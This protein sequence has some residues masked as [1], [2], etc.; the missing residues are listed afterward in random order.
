MTRILRAS[1]CLVATVALVACS[2]QD[3][4]DDPTD[5]PV[6]AE[7]RSPRAEQ[8]M[9]EV[10]AELA[11]FYEQSLRWEECGDGF[12]CTEVTVPLD[13][14]EPDGET[15]TIAVKRRAAG[16]EEPVGSLLVN[17]G[18][19][20]GSGVQL[21]ESA[22]L[23]FSSELLDGFDVIGFDPRGVNDSSA[24]DC[25][26]DAELDRIR[27]EDYDE[28]A[29]GLAEFAS[30][31]EELAAACAE[32]TGDLLAHVDTVSAARDVDVVRHL[33]EE[34]RLD[35][36]GYSYGTHLGAVYA[37]LFPE[38][39]GRLVLDGAMDPS[40]GT[41]E[42]VRGQAAGF[43]R[44]LRV[45]VEDCLAGPG[46]PLT[47][48]V[49]TAVGQ[50]QQLLELA[51]HTPLPTGTDRELTAPLMFSGIIMPLYDDAYWMLLTSALDAAINQQDGS[52]L[53]LLADLSAERE[54]DGTYA[55]NST[56]ANI[57]INC[58]DYPVEGDLETWRAEAKELA[59]ISPT[60]GPALAFGDVTCD[61]WPHEPTV[62]R[63]P[64][65]AA[66][67]DPIVVIGTTGDPAT[68]Y[69][70]SEA[71]AA[72]LESGV[73]VTYEGEGHTAYGRAGECITEAVD[74]YLLDGTVPEDGLVC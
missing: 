29:E 10:P 40:L 47:G 41:G 17:P 64:V 9:P 18:G 16:V 32:N 48:D 19:P 1:L 58:I 11:T 61:A 50:V 22:S 28:T 4:D 30:A 26:D 33:L 53:L 54:P 66:G 60:F 6:A 49:D 25:V 52:Q 65:T 69:E 70:W 2:A 59:E 20:G 62:E 14:A 45:Y 68:P 5:P 56:E 24:V 37:E 55:T 27:A 23:L 39:V 12:D 51:S 13:Y 35:Y 67:A 71:L 15:I 72:Q 43:E 42:I 3:A 44:A 46:C 38:N 63:A 31:A 36:L 34:P 8:P 74:G 21:V 7:S 73:L 57:A